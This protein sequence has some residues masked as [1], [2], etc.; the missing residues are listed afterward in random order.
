MV[1]VS[2]IVPVYN[3]DQYLPRCLES[4][5]GQKLRE[6]EII[7]VNDGSTDRSGE[8]LTK[9]AKVDRRLIVL[10]QEN[11]G[12]SSARNAG[13][14]IAK[15]KYIGFVDSDDYV[16]KNMF[17]LLFQAAEESKC[18]F[19]ECDLFHDVDGACYV[20]HGVALY[21]SGEML[22][23]GRSVVWNKI[24][25][26]DWLTE[27]GVTFQNGLIYEDVAFYAMLI[28]HLRKVCY[29]KEPLIH[30]VQ[31]SHSINA[32]STLKTMQ[33]LDILTKIQ[34]YYCNHG[35]QNKFAKELEYLWVR[36]LLCSSL[37]RMAGIPDKRQRAYALKSS[38][39][40]L[41]K[42]YPNW[43]SNPY[44][45]AGKGI[46]HAFM[47][48]MNPVTY[49]LISYLLPEIEWKKNPIIPCLLKSK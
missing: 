33:I 41:N 42:M 17:Q 36:I 6:I 14:S 39:E 31:R 1:K 23:M 15:G 11:G 10:S 40:M 27:T 24:Y 8:I 20:E 46:K 34:E 4:L 44:L 25:L 28:P 13:L 49:R 22:M 30:Y 18:D 37:L 9:Y 19:A 45:K 38:W 21:N 3:V 2:I 29:V 16:E 5:L 35:Y 32:V 48:M 47:R 43:H 12:L 26:R 7:A